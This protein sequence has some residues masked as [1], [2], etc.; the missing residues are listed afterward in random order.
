MMRKHVSIMSTCDA[1]KKR[2]AYLAETQR[3]KQGTHPKSV[4]PTGSLT[5][6]DISLPLK[7]EFM[8]RIGT[9]RGQ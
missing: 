9:S 7:Q 8:S 6:T 4:G 5:I 2:E 3:L 1:G